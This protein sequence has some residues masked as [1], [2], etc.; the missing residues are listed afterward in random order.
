MRI[1]LFRSLSLQRLLAIATISQILGVVGLVGYLSFRNG[2]K[3][4]ED[5]S[6]RL[7][8]A[9]NYRVDQ[10]LTDYLSIPL[11]INRL[12]VDAAERGLLDIEDPQRL[13]YRLWNQLQAFKSV[14]YIYLSSLEGG[15]LAVGRSQQGALVIEQTDTYP[16]AGDYT[17]YT[18]NAQGRRAEILRTF[19]DQDA[20]TRPWFQAPI[21][22]QRQVWTEPF[23]YVGR[24][25]VIAISASSPLY[26]PGGSLQGVATVDLKLDR[27]SRFLRNLTRE[28]EDQIF[29]VTRSGQLL[30]ASNDPPTVIDQARAEIVQASESP[31]AMIRQTTQQL[32]RQF[33]SLATIERQRA[34]IDVGEQSYFVQ[35]NPW[36]DELGLNWLIVVMVPESR[37]MAQIDQNTRITILLCLLAVAIATLLA[38]VIARYISAPVLE[39]SVASQH[40]AEASRRQFADGRLVPVLKNLSIREFEALATTFHQMS[41]QLQ[42][43]YA[44]LEEYSQ[45]LE[46]KVKERTLALEEEV[47]VRKRAEQQS[48]EAKEAAEVANQAKSDFLANMSHELRSPLNAILGFAQMLQQSDTVPTEHHESATIISRSGEHLLSLINNVLDMSKIEAGRTTLFPTP[49]DL[50]RLLDDLRNMFS[51]RAQ[52]KRLELNFQYTPDLPVYIVTDQGKLRQVLINLLNNAIKFTAAGHV[53]LACQRESDVRLRF[54]VVDTGR[55][56]A[57]TE[58]AQA[59]EPFVQTQSGQETSSGTGLGLPISQNFVQLMGGELAIKSEP[60]QGTKATFSIRAQVAEHLEIPEERAGRKVMGLAANQPLYRLLIV[61]DKSDNR[62]LLKK[63]LKPL[64]FELQEAQN[65]QLAIEAALRWQPDLIFMDMRMPVLDGYKATQQIRQAQASGDLDRAPKIVALSASSFREEQTAAI[66]AGCDD[67]I[68]KPFHT[69]AIFE[70]LGHHLGVRYRYEFE[71]TQSACDDL[72]VVATA[73]DTPPLNRLSSLRPEVLEALESATRRLQWN[74]ILQIIESIGTD[75]RAL[76]TA[77]T[78]TVYNFQYARILNAIGGTE[79]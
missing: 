69:A 14:S 2:Q 27:I 23:N 64:G 60:Q 49:F 34:V 37:L 31:N 63:L 57:A 21:A 45:S 26:G 16:K 55:G 58:V 50:Y 11:T 73:S 25:S 3:T 38:A 4:V 9:I 30:A 65:G 8:S 61:D 62:K 22:A 36:R 10:E 1:P 53:T 44:K 32:E 76:A 77:L 6:D 74:Q 19:A 28:P 13:E 33:S 20:R 18:T 56:M 43:S 51:L 24:E 15:S 5:L 46:A 59:F 35:V 78:Q 67:F 68:Q 7:I 52:E 42:S 40:L 72:P 70:T 12:N 47:E 71:P 39:L 66:A 75:D 17:L 79:L 29:I 54:D 48:L 41:E